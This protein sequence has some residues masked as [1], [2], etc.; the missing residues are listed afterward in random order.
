[1]TPTRPPLTRRQSEVLAF[2]RG[3]VAREGVPPTSRAIAAHLGLRSPNAAMQHIK[4]MERKGHIT[5]NGHTSRNIRLVDDPVEE[6]VQAGA[7]ILNVVKDP[8]K[9]LPVSVA[10]LRL[11]EALKP[12]GAKRC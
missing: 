12:F 3:H 1:M 9:A 2:I 7:T 10:L 6:L 5:R 8:G 4:A 11:R